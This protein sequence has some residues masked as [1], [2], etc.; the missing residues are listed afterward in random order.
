VVT[1]AGNGT[2]AAPVA[3]ASTPTSSAPTSSAEEDEADG[4]MP[5]DLDARIDQLLKPGS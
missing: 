3:A 2:P 5:P 1:P 4:D